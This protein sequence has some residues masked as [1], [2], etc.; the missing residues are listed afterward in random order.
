MALWGNKD[1]K[2]VTGTVA[3]V[4][5]D[6]TVTGSGTAFTTELK[7]GQTLVIATVPYQIAS[8]QSDTA[9]ELAVAYAATSGTG[10]T[11]TANESPAYVPHAEK[12]T[13][14]GVDKD[15]ARVA[16][17]ATQ[18]TSAGWVQQT[19]GSGGRSGR[20]QY[21][22]LVALKTITGDAEDTVFPDA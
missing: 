22:T 7:A 11:V 9:L 2:A 18:I 4:Q 6:A 16:A 12:A 13:I 10:L 14:F 19:T 21:E 20:V 5:T 3:T 15:E 8:I 1:T 17:V